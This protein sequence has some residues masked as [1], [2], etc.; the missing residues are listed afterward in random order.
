MG[1]AP[2]HGHHH[3][4]MLFVSYVIKRRGG[5]ESD[6]HAAMS[7]SSPQLVEPSPNTLRCFDENV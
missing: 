1:Y 7:K 6:A 3:P 2:C 5:I 4:V